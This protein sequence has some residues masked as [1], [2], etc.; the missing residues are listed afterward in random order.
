MESFRNKRVSLG[1]NPEKTFAYLKSVPKT[2][3]QR[4]NLSNLSIKCNAGKYIYFV[5]DTCWYQLETSYFLVPPTNPPPQRNSHWKHFMDLF[6]F[7]NG[8]ACGKAVPVIDV[9]IFSPF[10][11]S[12]V[13]IPSFHF[14]YLTFSPGVRR[15]PRSLSEGVRQMLPRPSALPLPLSVSATPGW[16]FACS[17][18]NWLW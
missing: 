4:C 10:S 1:R 17:G 9:S 13:F 12:S 2:E 11:F 16:E 18:A 5:S 3:K 6:P 14:S 7:V 15:R 8:V